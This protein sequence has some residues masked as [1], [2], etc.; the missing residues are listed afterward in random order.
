MSLEIV[1]IDLMPY[2][3][4]W[5]KAAINND[6][7]TLTAQ[8]LKDE[9]FLDRKNDS[10]NTALMIAIDAGNL[11]AVEFLLI[12][13]AD[14]EYVKNKQN[15]TAYELLFSDAK[16]FINPIYRKIFELIDEYKGKPSGK[17]TIT[18]RH[19]KEYLQAIK[20]GKCLSTFKDFF[21][22]NYLPNRLFPELFEVHHKVS[23]KAI[24]QLLELGNLVEFE[25]FF[26]VDATSKELYDMMLGIGLKIESENLTPDVAVKILK[27]Y[28][29]QSM[30]YYL[31]NQIRYQIKTFYSCPVFHVSLNNKSYEYLN[32]AGLCLGV[33]LNDLPQVQLLSRSAFRNAKLESINMNNIV[34][35]LLDAEEA[36]LSEASL[37][38]ANLTKANFKNSKWNRVECE[39]SEFQMAHFDG[40]LLMNVNFK[41]SNCEKILMNGAKI[42][43]V[44]FCYSNLQ[45]SNFGIYNFNEDMRGAILKNVDVD[46][47]NFS[48]STF[49]RAE[50]DQLINLDKPE[51]KFINT[52]F[53]GVRWNDELRFAMQKY[54]PKAIFSFENLR[55]RLKS[56]EDLSHINL[57]YLNLTIDLIDASDKTFP[58]SS[59]LE[60]VKLSFSNLSGSSLEECDL[61]GADFE[62]ANLKKLNLSY[63]L[64]ENASFVKA[65]FDQTDFR[66]AYL[67]NSDFRGSIFRGITYFEN[68]DLSD[69][70]LR[71]ILFDDSINIFSQLEEFAKSKNLHN[72]ILPKIAIDYLENKIR[73]SGKTSKEYKLLKTLFRKKACLILSPEFQ[74]EYAISINETGR[75]IKVI[76][77]HNKRH[78]DQQILRLADLNY[79]YPL[80]WITPD[81]KIPQAFHRIEHADIFNQLGEGLS[82]FKTFVQMTNTSR[83]HHLALHDE[84]SIYNKD[85]V[86]NAV[87]SDLYESYCIDYLFKNKIL[88]PVSAYLFSQYKN[89]L[90]CI[91]KNQEQN[92]TL[93]YMTPNA[94]N[95]MNAAIHLL[96]DNNTF[97]WTKIELPLGCNFNSEHL[98]YFRKFEW[99]MGLL[100]KAYSGN[101]EAQ[102]DI[103]IIYFTGSFKEISIFSNPDIIKA[104]AWFKKIIG[105]ADD[106]SKKTYFYKASLFRLGHITLE[107]FICHADSVSHLEKIQMLNDLNLSADAGHDYASYDL[108]Y[109]YN[110]LSKNR[111]LETA[112]FQMLEKYYG[113]LQN[114]FLFIPEGE[115]KVSLNLALRDAEFVIAKHRLSSINNLSFRQ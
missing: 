67:H 114:K 52:N 16:Y 35:I 21:R 73:S 13:G 17:T 5:F 90:V 41:N 25:A 12:L 11:D 24:N 23:D 65:Y 97:E 77:S 32:L 88:T 36:E 27:D 58:K 53:I 22:E 6:I 7:K 49:Y 85:E 55:Q 26:K 31:L 61:L 39:K 75:L 100:R 66:N 1:K 46:G 102:Y 70:D 99:F 86:F 63:A 18:I 108:I 79:N 50:I 59:K 64:L 72:T 56:G 33:P 84:I 76:E 115:F 28:P 107:K 60:R 20:T 110:H 91:W 74:Q 19:I 45:F 34:G 98:A 40:A 87:N 103:A 9:L 3:F 14:L 10:G 30:R 4:E 69:V 82:N 80:S 37:K 47:A 8:Y 96:Y 83:D 68:A 15:K 89:K 81:T 109:Y 62:G 112:E 111:T 44:S 92:L 105:Y 54:H 2:G 57:S 113:H 51:T 101:I 43:S 94:I 106:I 95:N 48:Y 93:E 104:I 29:D 42:Y 38:S 78:S 71:D